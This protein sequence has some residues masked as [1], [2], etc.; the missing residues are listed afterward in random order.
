MTGTVCHIRERVA[1]TIGENRFR[2]WFG[3]S[4]EFVLDD[5]RLSILV[6]ND[7]VG[8]WIAT[9]YLQVI[10]DVTRDVVGSHLPVE[11]RVRS[12]PAPD[13]NGAG[14]GS[15]GSG[16][17]N[18]QPAGSQ[19]GRPS[20]NGPAALPA[21]AVP[22]RTPGAAPQLRG[23]LETFI[24][25]PS[26]RLAF[27]AAQQMARAPGETF[28]LLVLHGDCGLGK[29][30]LLQGICNAAQRSRP[31]LVWFYISGEQFTNEY[32]AAVKS[33]R[34]E[35]FRARYRSADLLAIDDIHFLANKKATQDEFLHTFDAID[36][37]G[38]AVVLSSDRHPRTIA[39]LSDA[40]INRLISGMVIELHEPDYQTRREILRQRSA[41]L[42]CDLADEVL[43]FVARQITRNVRE[44]EG[45][46][47]KLVALARLTG[48]P[49]T[50]ELACLALDDHLEQAR[51]AVSAS[52]VERV[53]TEYFGVTR[54]QIY[55]KSRGRTIS[56]ARAVAMYLVRKYTNLS[57]P[58][59][60][61]LMGE[62][63]H[64]TVL[65]AAKRVEEW[66]D[67]GAA[68]GWKNNGQAHESAIHEVLGALERNLNRSEH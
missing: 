53:V 24:V 23:E 35:Y 21:G 46:L 20:R 27:A 40:L 57:F 61:R 55:S 5:Q 42:A 12:L 6:S 51:R 58:E 7:F 3:D 49:I 63:N 66:L 9:N 26:N 15:N 48:A 67:K 11:I 14:G 25:G 16:S 52:D 13:A 44:L 43:D 37:A 65:M 2:T 59:I 39:T 1:D 34:T 60:G 56:V 10:H 33:N 17:S 8:N 36:A 62:K 22:R 18:G 45:A 19:R 29:T 4:A 30:H 47:L 68:I 38:K 28:K 32:I 50:L 54:S 64:S 31:G 41:A